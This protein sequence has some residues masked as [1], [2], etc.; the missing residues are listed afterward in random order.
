MVQPSA[1]AA[2]GGLGDRGLADAGLT[3][4]DQHAEPAL[5]GRGP[6][7]G[8]PVQHLSAADKCCVAKAVVC[9][10]AH[11]RTVEAQRTVYG[12]SSW[13]TGA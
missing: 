2:D 3:L 9:G 6:E 13:S 5:T 4:D 7:R 10:N 11:D 1:A 12:V 8:D